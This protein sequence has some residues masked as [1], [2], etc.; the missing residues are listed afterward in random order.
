MARYTVVKRVLKGNIADG[1]EQYQCVGD[2]GSVLDMSW[3]CG[4]W[5]MAEGMCKGGLRQRQIDAAGYIY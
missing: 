2:S 1:S 5:P 4:T 3:D